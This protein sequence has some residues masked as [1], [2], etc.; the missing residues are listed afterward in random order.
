MGA[1][2]LIKVCVFIVFP[3]FVACGAIAYFGGQVISHPNSDRFSIILNCTAIAFLKNIDEL[4]YKVL[5]KK[6]KDEI[7][8]STPVLLFPDLHDDEANKAEFLNIMLNT[9]AAFAVATVLYL[10]WTR[11]M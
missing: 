7:N 6:M 1:W 4:F 11:D 8:E 5:P 2:F 10:Y 9:I 3:K